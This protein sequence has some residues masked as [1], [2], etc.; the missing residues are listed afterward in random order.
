MQQYFRVE[1]SQTER[2]ELK[3]L[4]SG[5]Q[6]ARRLTAKAEDGDSIFVLLALL[7]DGSFEEI[8]R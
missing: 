5:I 7:V 6:F 4:L 8:C 1:L 2:D 3:G